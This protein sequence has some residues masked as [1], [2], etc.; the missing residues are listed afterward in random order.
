[1]NVSRVITLALKQLGV[2]AAGENASASEIADA[3]DSLRALLA[4][5]ATDRLYVYKVLPITLNLTGKGTYT[6]DQTIDDIS[7]IGKLDDCE[8]RLVRDLNDTGVYVKVRY[9]E[10][11]PFWKFDVL[12]DA[13]KLEIKAFTLPTALKSHDEVEIPPKYERALI[14]SLALDIA[15][16]FGVDPS[17]LLVKNQASALDLLKRS[18]STPTYAK[19]D[20]PVGVCKGWNYGNYH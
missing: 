18:N 9:I 13:K 8:T 1:M 10:E 11:N 6:L 5:W 16:M 17:M 4:Q 20:L 7:D 19:N 15:P 12:C 3:V 14:L 2:L